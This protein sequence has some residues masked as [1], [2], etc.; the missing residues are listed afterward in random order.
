M[1]REIIYKEY[2]KKYVWMLLFGLLSLCTGIGYMVVQPSENLK[3]ASFLLCLG[4]A[5]VTLYRFIMYY[6]SNNVIKTKLTGE[7]IQ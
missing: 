6:D 5:V 3:A 7:V 2:K 4:G 1:K